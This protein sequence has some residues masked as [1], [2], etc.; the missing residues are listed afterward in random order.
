MQSILQY[1]LG[2]SLYVMAISQFVVGIRKM[3]YLA[4]TEGVTN[5][6]HCMLD[7]GY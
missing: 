2:M 4:G 1:V 3:T 5:Q 6:P 7:T